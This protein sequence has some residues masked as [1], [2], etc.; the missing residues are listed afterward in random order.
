MQRAIRNESV[1]QTGRFQ[2]ID[3]E[4]QLP[5]RRQRRPGIPFD[6]HLAGKTVEVYAR[7]RTFVFNRRLFTRRVKGWGGEI[8][9]H[10][11]DNATIRAKSKAANCRF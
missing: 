11:P 9:H 4:R 3:E 6:T 1:E 8:V 10:A 7:R 2:E 5:E